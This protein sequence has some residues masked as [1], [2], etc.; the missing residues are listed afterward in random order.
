MSV[1][2]NRLF[3]LLSCATVMNTLSQDIVQGV[4][5]D[6]D[7]GLVGIIIGL[8]DSGPAYNELN[9]FLRP[10]Q[11]EL[12][13]IVASSCCKNHLILIMQ[14]FSNLNLMDLIET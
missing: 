4:Q 13:N 1:D 14:S 9:H 3:L 6:D 11:P 2:L 12:I 8:S 5:Y 10:E 7:I